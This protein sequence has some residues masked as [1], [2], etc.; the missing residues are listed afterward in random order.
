VDAD[1]TLA[2]PPRHA[3][4][5]WI[6]HLSPAV[7]GGRHPVKRIVGEPCVVGAD[8]LRDGHDR[9]AGRIVFRG[10]GDR[11]WSHAPLVHDY[12]GDRWTGAFVPTRVGRW[13]FSVEA[14]TDRFATWRHALATRL[15]A[16]RDVAT[17]LAE[18]AALFDEAAAHAAGTDR[19][20]LLRVAASVGDAGLAAAERAALALHEDLVALVTTSLPRID[21]T[22]A[23]TDLTLVADRERARFAAWYE[24]FPRSQ[25]SAPGCPATLAEAARRLPALADLGFDVVYLPPIHPIGVTARKGPNGTSAA[26]PNDPGSPWAIGSAAGGHTAVDP[27]LGTLAD[28]DRFV[29]TAAEL[30]M[31]VALDYAPHCSPDHPWVREHPDWFQHHP[32]GS[33]RAAENPPYTFEDIVPFD[34]WC[35]DREAL[36]A[37]LRDVFL[38]W[39]GHGVRT[40]RVDNPHTKPFAF[41]EWVIESVK[42]THPDVL[43]LAESFT[44]PKPMRALSA[45]GFSQSYTYFIWRTTAAELREYFTELTQGELAEVLR[46]A[47]FPTTPDVLHRYLQTGGRAA[48]RVRLVLAATLSPLYGIYSGYELCEAEPLHPDGE[49]YRDSEKFQIRVRDWD[50]PG[51]VNAD[52]ALLNRL[53]RAHRA[54]QRADNLAFCDADNAAILCYAKRGATPEETLLVAV[55]LDPHAAQHAQ[56]DVPLA[57]WQREAATPFTVEDLLTGERWDWSGSRAYVRLDPAEHVAHVFRLAP[58]GPST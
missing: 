11:A 9:L 16:G 43:F 24:M 53:R 45:L 21:L 42:A 48:F 3:P 26:G 52:L 32:D 37:A 8:I 13:T 30:G 23:A 29:A 54:L 35:R 51:N 36:W 12:A 4:R 19:A 38:F 7:D 6:E 34:F 40:F 10:P 20:T 1:R 58:P 49:E 15:E 31:E 44:R 17:D 50:A 22:R 25:G 56:V 39:I 18:G 27:A 55:N 57:L 5:L 28:F 2:A 33:L 14:W 47:L 46:G 41:W